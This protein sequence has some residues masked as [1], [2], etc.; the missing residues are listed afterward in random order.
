MDIKTKKFWVMVG[1]NLIILGGM[2]FEKVVYMD[3][4]QYIVSVAAGWGGL[5]TVVKFTK[6]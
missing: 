2:I 6:K 5:D 1:I 4:V 3:G